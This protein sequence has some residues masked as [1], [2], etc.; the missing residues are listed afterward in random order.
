MNLTEMRTLVRRDLHDEDGA[1]YRWTNDE[2]DRHIA[3]AVKE[4]SEAIP[5]EQK[6]TLSTTAGSREISIATL[7]NRIMIEAVEYPVDKFPKNYQRFNLWNDTITLLGPEVPDGSNCYIY[8][9]KLHTLDGS[10]STIPAKYEDL[11]TTGAAGY[12]ACEWSIYSV[13]HINTGGTGTPEEFRTRGEELISHFRSEIKRLG[14]KNRVRTN[15]IYIPYYPP[16]S[17]S[18]D[19]W[20]V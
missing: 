9:G 19:G 20:L 15:Q 1:N 8:Y 11:V 13:N 16:V 17:Q 2:I 7:T 14:R 4:F 3:R 12:A 5:L 18:R 10:S 6:A